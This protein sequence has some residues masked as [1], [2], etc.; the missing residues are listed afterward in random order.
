MTSSLSHFSAPAASSAGA[1]SSNT[2][3][4][5]G[6][7]SSDA[8][9]GDFADLICPAAT[10][11]ATTAQPGAAPA[12]ASVKTTTTVTIAAPTLLTLVLNP[13]ALAAGGTAATQASDSTD[14]VPTADSVDGETESANRPISRE[15]MEQAASFLAA[16]LQALL[17]QAPAPSAAQGTTGTATGASPADADAPTGLLEGPRPRGPV[18]VA[19]GTTENPAEGATPATP[20]ATT[21]P[22]FQLTL[23]ADGSVE[24]RADLAANA[25]ETAEAKTGESAGSETAGADTRSQSTGAT[26]STGLFEVQ[27]E[28]ALPGR[29]VLRI[30]ASGGAGK[31]S[32]ARAKFAA[33]VSGENAGAILRTRAGERNFLNADDKEVTTNDT[34]AGIGVAKTPR[35]MSTTATTETRVADNTADFSSRGQFTVTW[36]SAVREVADT[37][38]ASAPVEQNFAERAVATVSNLVDTQFTAAMQKSGSVQLRLKFG[39]ED[40]SVRVELRGGV[41]HTD[42]KTDSAEL[43]AALNREWQAVQSTS[44]E[45]LSHFIDPVFSPSSSNGHDAHGQSSSGRQQTAMQQDDSQQQRQ[46]RVRGEDSVT[47][48]R[49]AFAGDTFASG[50][51]S[52]AAPRVPGHLPTSLRL[53]VLA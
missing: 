21:P 29:A 7:A 45:K 38:S 23:A 40:L 14:A 13:S 50:S 36:P 1:A 32:G 53:S 46:S 47:V 43:R 35:I 52:T 34:G 12:T 2:A 48:T 49:R 51:A 33:G 25:A 9:A 3:D 11:P 17:P 15:T 42:F 24:I 4:R 19:N 41:V 6:P 44:P 39:G 31:D 37:A 22:H 5:S 30:S 27:A 20:A 10:N 8:P 26:P 28:L 18:S 16:V